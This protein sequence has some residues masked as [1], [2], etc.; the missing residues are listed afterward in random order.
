MVS[1]SR[2]PKYP[3]ISLGDTITYARRL[4]VEAHK[5]KVDADTAVQ[6]MGFSG[7]SGA[8]SVA[9]G[10]VR[11]FG[12]VDGLRGDIQIS[13]LALRILQ[14]V[15]RQEEEEAML[16]AAMRPDVFDAL[17]I[18][19]ERDFPKSDEPIKAHLIRT[20]GFS[21]PGAIECVSSLRKTLEEIER[22]SVSPKDPGL[23]L[24]ESATDSHS[25]S[26]SSEPVA[27][28]EAV[29][30]TQITSAQEELVRIPLSKSCTAELRL[31]GDI[32]QTSIDRLVQ[33]IELMRGVWAE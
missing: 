20:M 29:I 16:E 8:S 22:F 28:P 17:S 27:A 5:A 19:F 7:K 23:G 21:Q 2:S 3:R 11:Q 4:Y 25:A 26:W 12:L 9:L 1:R 33:Y 24:I 31:I 32:D 15:S 18:H 6:L 10:A 13:D 14:P 30:S